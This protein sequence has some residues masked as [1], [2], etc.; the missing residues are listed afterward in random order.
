M[1]PDAAHVLEV[2]KEVF[3]MHTPLSFMTHHS[4]QLPIFRQLSH[5]VGLHAMFEWEKCLWTRP[6]GRIEYSN[7]LV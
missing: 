3:R 6:G 1:S 5:L 4:L 7:R 2:F